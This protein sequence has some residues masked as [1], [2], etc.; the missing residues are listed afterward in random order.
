[1]TLDPK[2]II[3]SFL[4]TANSAKEMLSAKWR[5]TTKSGV[6]NVIGIDLLGRT[7]SVMAVMRYGHG[8]VEVI[9]SAEGCAK[10]RRYEI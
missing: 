5:T 3:N 7:N 10:W 8:H 1:L 4:F 6:S 2:I 9:A